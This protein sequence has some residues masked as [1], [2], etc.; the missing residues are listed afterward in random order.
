MEKKKSF[1]LWLKENVF[2]E[3]LIRV[4]LFGCAG[5]LVNL[6]FM[7]QSLNNRLPPPICG[8]PVA[9][10]LDISR[11]Q[12][13]RSREVEKKNLD[14]SS[15][16]IK[17]AQHIE[18]IF[19]LF[20]NASFLQ[21]YGECLS[22]A[23]LQTNRLPF[24]TISLSTVHQSGT[25]STSQTTSQLEDSEKTES[26][27]K[28]QSLSGSQKSEEVVSMP[29]QKRRQMLTRLLHTDVPNQ[30]HLT[31]PGF[32]G[33][34]DRLADQGYSP[35]FLAR[36][37]RLLNHDDS[38]FREAFKIYE[39]FAD[40][41]GIALPEGYPRQQ[42][43]D[44]GDDHQLI[45]KDRPQ[46]AQVSSA[47]KRKHQQLSQEE[48]EPQ[49]N[50]RR[51]QTLE[52]SEITESFSMSE[53]MSE[54]VVSMPI[55]KRRQMLTRLLHTDVPNQAHLAS[56]NTDPSRQIQELDNL[57]LDGVLNYFDDPNFFP[58]ING[59]NGVFDDTVISED[60]S[61]KSPVVLGQKRK[62]QES[63]QKIVEPQKNVR[64]KNTVTLKQ[65][66][67][68]QDKEKCKNWFNNNV[69]FEPNYKVE[70]SLLY[71][72]Y[73]TSVDKE[74]AMSVL[75]VAD[76]TKQTLIFATEQDQKVTIQSKSL[77]GVK[78]KSKDSKSITLKLH[79]QE[80]TL[81]ADKSPQT[82]D[83][84]GNWFDQKIIFDSD[85]KSRIDH[86]YDNY[87]N[88]VAKKGMTTVLDRANFIKQTLVLAKATEQ[89]Q[90]VTIQSNSLRG[91]KKSLCGLGLQK[92][93]EQRAEYQRRY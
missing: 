76:F 28:T 71:K 80:I 73:R 17:N 65:T 21:R 69:I 9:A 58:D 16:T 64:S 5:F 25:P 88:W 68:L 49:R 79:N 13:W 11:S 1:S 44:I 31:F 67:H 2:V 35:E 41:N 55:Q 51:K 24:A 70:I 63:S 56:N 15:A 84:H 29:I 72:R 81:E 19:E 27:E 42:N 7:K 89:G 18:S 6:R 20:S 53:A 8:A 23:Y 34:G 14:A 43:S 83:K 12:N 40:A 3:K 74:G 33:L 10:T 26:L 85:S 82:I 93:Q 37:S 87:F 47:L 66:L 62:R 60:H 45:S 92:T 36:V 54:E 52:D 22:K 39:D 32:S 50:V 77:C 78:L 90:K 38:D 48:V 61:E 57:D 46:E 30:A 59:D 91:Q 86:L 75:S 4:L